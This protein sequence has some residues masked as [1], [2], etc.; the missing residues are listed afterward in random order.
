M[1]DSR[2]SAAPRYRAFTADDIP[3]A[4]G[5]SVAVQWPHRAEDWREMFDAGT[6]FV[7]E[8]AGVVIGTALCWKFGADRGTLGLVIV[9]SEQQGRGIG[10]KLMEL[11]L[12][13]LGGRITFLHAT[14]AGKPLY[15]KLGFAECG[16]I[17]QHQGPIG[18]VAAIAPPEGE[19]L[20]AM[21]RDDLATVVELASRASGFDRSA[22]IPA[23]LESAHAQG[24]VLERDGAIVGFSLLR[25]FG[26]GQVIGPVV[27]TDAIRAKSL[28]THWLAQH[29]G[30]FVRMDVPAGTGINDWLASVGLKHVSSVVKMVRNAPASEH[31]GPPDATYRAFGI[32]NQAMA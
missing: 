16:S 25:R 12:E 24:I 21:T 6:G 5:L 30:A 1:S 20:R 3:A 19:R 13:E 2:V 18:D 11:V 31:G 28:I 15:E 7:A 27:A 14:E 29:A 17:D 10:R 32:I 8:D 9:S 22:T 23:L 26:R 4:H